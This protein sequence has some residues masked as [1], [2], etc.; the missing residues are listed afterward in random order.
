MPWLL[1]VVIAILLAVQ[2]AVPPS[3]GAQNGAPTITF[4]LGPKPDSY[5]IAGAGFDPGRPV[6]IL[7]MP[8]G[9]LPCAAEP[10]GPE[11][12]VQPPTDGSFTTTYSA[13][14]EA[15]FGRDYRLIIARQAPQ[16]AGEEGLPFVNVPVHHP[17]TGSEV[18]PPNTGSSLPVGSGDTTLVLL[19]ALCVALGGTVLALRRP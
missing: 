18:K 3:A 19:G 13:N 8:C 17:G 12:K 10:I 5:V 1:L 6:D 16:L 9:E 4:T 15:E 7:E 14:T 11:V 2:V